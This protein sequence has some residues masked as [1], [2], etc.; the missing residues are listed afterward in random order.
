MSSWVQ[1][2]LAVCISH[3]YR[4]ITSQAS[5]L[6]FLGWVAHTTV[7][8]QFRGQGQREV[9]EALNGNQFQVN[10]F[11]FNWYPYWPQQIH[12]AAKTFF[13]SQATIT[14]CSL[15]PTS[16]CTPTSKQILPASVFIINCVNND[17]QSIHACLGLYRTCKSK[18]IPGRVTGT[19]R[20]PT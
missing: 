9:V 17:S 3:V 14:P 7:Q 1:N 5:Q 16:N 18:D 20:R 8:T 10:P 12:M 2:P 4:V 6:L 15:F 19:R 13:H 11:K